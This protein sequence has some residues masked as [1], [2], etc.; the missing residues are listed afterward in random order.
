MQL[1]EGQNRRVLTKGWSAEEERVIA[2]IQETE[3]VSRPEATRMQ[4]PPPSI[5][6]LLAATLTTYSPC[7]G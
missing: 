3:L 6:A 5:R 4:T 1:N 2:T 7:T